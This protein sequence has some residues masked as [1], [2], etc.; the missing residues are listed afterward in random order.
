MHTEVSSFVKQI[1]CFDR[2]LGLPIYGR[3]RKSE[4]GHRHTKNDVGMNSRL[5]YMICCFPRELFEI[6]RRPDQKIDLKVD[7]NELE[8]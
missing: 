3:S 8:L 5:Q 2:S 4:L 6:R 7:L 1:C